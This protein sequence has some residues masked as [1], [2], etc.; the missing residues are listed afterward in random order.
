MKKENVMSFSLGSFSISPSG[1][2]VTELSSCQIQFSF[3]SPNIGHFISGVSLRV[4]E[5]QCSPPEIKISTETFL[6]SFINS[7][8]EGMLLK[9]KRGN[10]KSF[11]S[12]YYLGLRD[13]LAT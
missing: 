9:D 3:Q 7:N 4:S 2:I 5:S 11:F 6:S 8:N 10:D 1:G 13:S 12:F